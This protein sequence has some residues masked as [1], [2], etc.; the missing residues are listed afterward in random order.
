MSEKKLDEKKTI[1]QMISIIMIKIR[2]PLLV[3][4]LLSTL[5]AV[6][7]GIYMS[8]SEASKKQ[9]FAELENY[10]FTL[11]ESRKILT[12]DEFKEKQEEILQSITEFAEKNIKNVV[13][14]RAFMAI[15]DI[16]F[17][18]KN[19][20]EARDAWLQAAEASPKTYTAMISYY[21]AAVVSEETNDL[22]SATDYYTRVCESTNFPLISHALF[23]LARVQ[24][25]LGNIE[26]A[27][28]HYEKLVE[29]FPTD[30]W[31]DIARTRLAILSTETKTE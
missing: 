22:Q 1:S 6:G 19:W 26:I 7:V 5:G 24:D 25:E 21:N 30:S 28:T 16:Q 17:E 14:A 12:E 20:T 31:A 23:S 18:K 3:I 15:A 29:K 9:K 27:K 11:T 4:I 2:V 10:T 13:G 8:V